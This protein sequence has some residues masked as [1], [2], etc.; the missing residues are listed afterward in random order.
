[1]AWTSPR[2]WVVGETLTAA[3]LNAH[4]RDNML[5]LD[6]DR[7]TWHLLSSGTGTATQVNITP[8]TAGYHR[9]HLMLLADA[10]MSADA[11]FIRLNGDSGTN[12]QSRRYKVGG[13]AVNSTEATSQ[14][15][16][17]ICDAQNGEEMAIDLHIMNPLTG[18]GRAHIKGTL[19]AD[20]TEFWEFSGFLSNNGET[21]AI[22]VDW[23]NSGDYRYAL[24]GNNS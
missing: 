12:Y 13:D 21:D 10:S 20:A 11:V 16:F 6:A 17:V 23:V 2:T 4:V 9:L 7:G 15:S 8:F 22:L 24:L 5:D 14:T 19:D 3:L 18:L 1:M